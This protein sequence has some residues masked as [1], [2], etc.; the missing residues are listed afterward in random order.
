MR[1]RPSWR[2]RYGILG[3]RE[4]HETKR[5]EVVVATIPVGNE[6]VPHHQYLDRGRPADRFHRTERLYL[7]VT[8]A[9]AIFLKLC[10]ERLEELRTR[11]A[12]QNGIAEYGLIYDYVVE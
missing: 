11:F 3:A 1:T 8:V 9:S 6:F 7:M 4:P 12:K 10:S 2:R 5:E